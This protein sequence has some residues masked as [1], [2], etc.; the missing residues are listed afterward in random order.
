MATKLFVGSLPWAVDDAQL[1]EMFSSF[2]QVTSAKVI[3]DRETNRSKGF[4][5]VEFDDDNAAKAAIDKLNNTEMNGRNIVVNEA[6]PQ[7]PRAPR[8]DFGD[9]RY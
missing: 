7:E 1:E 4:G 9:K 8:R 2:G 6:R 3:V 5:F